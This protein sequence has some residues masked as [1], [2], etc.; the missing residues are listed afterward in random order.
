MIGDLFHCF[1]H[2]I[3]VCTFLKA[4]FPDSTPWAAFANTFFKIY[5]DFFIRVTIIFIELH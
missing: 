5:T 1:V 4:S 2:L 3:Y